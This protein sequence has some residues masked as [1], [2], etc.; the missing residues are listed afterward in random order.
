MLSDLQMKEY[1]LRCSVFVCPSVIENS[2]NSPGEAMLLGVPIAASRTGGI[3]DMVNEN[4][5][6]VLFEKGNVNDIVKAILQLWDEPVIAA[7][8]G[9]NASAHARI[10]HNPDTNFKRLIEIYKDI[11]NR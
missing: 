3:P 2:P 8:Y 10:T 4:K 9:D 1:F 6:G 7:V 11:Y 5:D